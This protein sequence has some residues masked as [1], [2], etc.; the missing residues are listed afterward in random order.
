MVIK[1]S[2]KKP[3][4]WRY[5]HRCD[6]CLRKPAQWLP[7]AFL[8]LS[9]LASERH[10]PLGTTIGPVLAACFI[11]PVP[12][13]PVIQLH[14]QKQQSH[15]TSAPGMPEMLEP[16]PVGWFLLAHKHPAMWIRMHRQR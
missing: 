4:V 14:V 10:L 5:G 1:E 15:K 11:W 9:S 16:A 8:V 7:L 13:L 12:G 2:T 6:R 3:E